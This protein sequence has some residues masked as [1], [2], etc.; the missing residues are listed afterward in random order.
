MFILSHLKYFDMIHCKL[1]HQ[2]NERTNENSFD[3]NVYIF[4]TAKWNEKRKK[5]G[6]KICKAYEEYYGMQYKE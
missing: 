6:T 1:A 3:Q 2:T 4:V 5:S